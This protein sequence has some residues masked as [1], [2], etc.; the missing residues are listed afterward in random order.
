[1]PKIKTEPS[2]DRALFEEARQRLMEATDH[3]AVARSRAKEDLKFYFGDSDNGYQWPIE[4]RKNRDIDKKPTL[5]VNQTRQH[6]LNILN[7]ARQNPPEIR[8]LPVGDK[9]TYEGAEVYQGIIR[10]IGNQSKA[11]NA[12]DRARFYQVVSGWGYWRVLTEYS[13]DTSG[14]QDVVI[15]PI[16]NPLSVALDPHAEQ[17][18]KSD[19]DYAF[20]F[21]DIP[22]D[23]FERDYP[24]WKNLVRRGA[25]VGD[26][27]EWNDRN[28][29]RVCEYYRR[30]K[31]GRLVGTVIDRGMPRSFI[32]DELPPELWARLKED[33][34]FYSRESVSHDVEWYKIVGDTVVE[35]R[36]R[37][38]GDLWPGQ[39]I[40][41]VRIFGEESEID[42]NY[43]CRGHVR[44]LKDPNRMYNF[45]TS[46]IA[47]QLSAQTKTPWLTSVRAIEGLESYW[48]DANIVNY[49]ALP[50]N[51]IDD[52]G[53]PVQPPSRMQPPIL[54]DAYVRGLTVSQ[55]EMRM[56]SGQWQEDLGQ[57][58]NAQSGIAI[59]ARVR[60][61]D[62]S[63]QHFVEHEAV[64]LEY[65]GCIMLE[66]I[67]KIYDTRRIL[68]ILGEDGIQ[69]EIALD[70]SAL[71]EIQEQQSQDKK[72]IAYIFNPGFGRYSVTVA[73]GPSFRTRREE[74]FSAMSQILQASPQMVGIIGDLLFKSADFPLSD[75]IAERLHAGIP[76]HILGQGPTP[77][78]VATQQTLTQLMQELAEA[79]NKQHTEEAKV[80]I[81]DFRAQTERLNA[82]LKTFDPQALTRMIYDAVVNVLATRL[83]QPA[84][85]GRANPSPTLPPGAPSAPGMPVT[86]PN[87]GSA[88]GGA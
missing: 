83:P 84:D 62:L 78:E 6:C 81:E 24:E 41:V 58:S 72:K 45:W 43:D 48:K 4:V 51:D 44:W 68:R 76:P 75:E 10:H 23:R 69:T 53:R 13:D 87:N 67:P 70:P 85:L 40:P 3:E 42:G 60:Q 65:T 57:Q 49:S 38:T 18:D 52:Q 26:V 39:H 27:A 21:N 66:I 37:G 71:R 77:Q 15:C 56:A 2:K 79:R 12:F 36:T 86:P 64:G 16:N 63:T 28:N 7:A 35:R 50:Y 33:V 32:K 9:A 55:Q 34:T 29:V 22:R 88:Y 74:A 46:S 80:S 8:I 31:R 11:R 47:E 20:I 25:A 19:M 82:L 5:T 73:V 14:D 61:S 59:N 1:M 54:A 17:K 30:V